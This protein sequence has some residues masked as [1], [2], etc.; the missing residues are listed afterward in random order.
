MFGMNNLIIKD[1]KIFVSMFNLS[2][3][4]LIVIVLVKFD[5]YHTCYKIR[6]CINCI[7]DLL[8]NSARKGSMKLFT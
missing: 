8:E 5:F 3:I 2:F 1:F 4:R 7:F 6:T